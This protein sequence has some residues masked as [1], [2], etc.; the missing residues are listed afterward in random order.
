MVKK[1]KSRI[2][3]L[4]TCPYLY[5]LQ[6]IDFRLPDYQNSVLGKIGTEVHKIFEQF[7][8]YINIEDIPDIPYQY[9]INIMNVPLHYKNVYNAF[10]EMESR[11]YVGLEDKSTYMPI[12]L[13]KYLINGDESGIIDRVDYY[14]NEYLVLDYKSSTSNPSKLR[15]ELNFYKKLLDESSILDKPVKY[16]GAYGYRTGTLFIEEVSKR[17]YNSM[18]R[19]VEA[20]ELLDFKNIN[21]E[22][23]YGFPCKSWCP[24]RRSCLR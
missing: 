7:F 13:E 21:Y 14:K 9:F 5:K 2:N 22:K 4:G 1:T 20:F 12:F 23:K 3:T 24:Y 17:S 10:C 16:I 15:F 19:K 11:R 8:G 18:L 6:Y